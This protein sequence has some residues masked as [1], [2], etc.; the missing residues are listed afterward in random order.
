MSFLLKN[1][2]GN[3]ITSLI[4]EFTK[5]KSLNTYKDCMVLTRQNKNIIYKIIKN[6][7]NISE[8]TQFIK[9]IIDF[10]IFTKNIGYE[11]YSLLLGIVG[12]L[13]IFLVFD[14]FPLVPT[15][16]IILN[17]NNLIHQYN[18]SE[19]YTLSGV[20]SNSNK[21]YYNILKKDKLNTLELKYWNNLLNN[22]TELVNILILKILNNKIS[23][24]YN[25]I[26]I[27]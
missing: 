1:K 8:K 22:S 14:E 25:I 2:L 19:N 18:I 17:E 13:R 9:N 6:S 4:Y 21:F 16:I 20:L 27:I 15:N 12:T 7:E 11:G 26:N 24:Y 3:D 23:I 10:S 5:P